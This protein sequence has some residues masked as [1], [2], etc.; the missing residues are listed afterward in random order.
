MIIIGSRNTTRKKRRPAQ[1]LRAQERQPQARARTARATPDDDVDQGDDERARPAAVAASRAD[2]PAPAAPR[3]GATSRRP[4]RAGEPHAGPRRRCPAR[5]HRAATTTGHDDQPSRAGASGREHAQ[6]MR[7]ARC[8]TAASGSCQADEAERRSR[9]GTSSTR[10]QRQV[11]RDEEREDRHD[12]RRT[13]TAGQMK[14]AAPAVSRRDAR[15]RQAA[16]RD[17]VGGEPVR[18]GAAAAAGALPWSAHAYRWTPSVARRPQL[19]VPAQLVGDLVPARLDDLLH[20]LRR[21]VDL[22]GEELGDR[23]VEHHLLVVLVLRH[24]Q[25]EHHVRAVEAVLDGAQVVLG[26]RPRSCRP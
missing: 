3:D 7:T 17:G 5:Q 6:E 25:V 26:R 18:P 11:E 19:L 22:A 9:P 10:R 1:V 2:E 23:R 15:R 13:S 20:R 16:R 14:R 21:L 4:D 12:A 24:A 8:R